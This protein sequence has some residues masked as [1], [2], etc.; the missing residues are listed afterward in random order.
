[1]RMGGWLLLDGRYFFFASLHFSIS[2]SVGPLG[3]GFFFVQ[4]DKI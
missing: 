1:M 2:C 4:L 3:G